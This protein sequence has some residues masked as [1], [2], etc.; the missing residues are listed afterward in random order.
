M[1]KKLEKLK[2]D[3]ASFVG[4]F[5]SW[6]ADK[7]KQDQEDIKKLQEEVKKLHEELD[8]VNDAILGVGIALAATL[9][10]TGIL[11]ICF[12]PAAPFILVSNSLSYPEPTNSLTRYRRLALS[13][14]A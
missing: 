7:E 8:S 12:A 1:K 13:S 3:F 4:T 2:V 9:P 5:S 10:L 6:S 11:A 14:P